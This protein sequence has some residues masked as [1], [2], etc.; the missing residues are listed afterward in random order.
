MGSKKKKKVCVGRYIVQRRQMVES[1]R[2]LLCITKSK[3]RQSVNSDW[4]AETSPIAFSLGHSEMKNT[5]EK[6]EGNTTS[7]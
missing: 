3:G 7:R 6:S 2:D 5:R 4:R 1:T